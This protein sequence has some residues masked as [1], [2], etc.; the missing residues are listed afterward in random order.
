[1]NFVELKGSVEVPYKYHFYETEKNAVFMLNK[2]F[3]VN[4]IT[5]GDTWMCIKEEMVLLLQCSIL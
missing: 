5:V 4:F 1:V 3:V 2:F